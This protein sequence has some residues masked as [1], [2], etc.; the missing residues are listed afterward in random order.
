MDKIYSRKRIK[1]P[2]IKS[3]NKNK[4]LLFKIFVTILIL[5][6]LFGALINKLMPSIKELSVSK[7]KSTATLI[8]N[9]A[10]LD[11]MKDINYSDLIECIYDENGNITML[12]A[13]TV[14]MNTLASNITNQIQYDLNDLNKTDITIPLGS[15]SNNQLFYGTGPDVTI[16]IM[17]TGSI[18]TKFSSELLST[19]INQTIHRIYVEIS[20]NIIILGPLT[21]VIGEFKNKI[22]IAETVIVGNVPSTFLKLDGLNEWKICKK[23]IYIFLKTSIIYIYLFLDWRK[24]EK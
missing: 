1:L 22:P 4:I 21:N 20:C 7:A 6:L 2:K 17:Q 9:N 23:S 15:L 16:K 18:D 11:K 19:G 14:K 24:N 8:C 5:T 13:N 10:I 12:K 3:N